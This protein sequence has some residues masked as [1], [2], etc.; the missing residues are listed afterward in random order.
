MDD[1]DAVVWSRFGCVSLT[2]DVEKCHWDRRGWQQS[3]LSQYADQEVV[4]HARAVDP[5][6]ADILSNIGQWPDFIHRLN[7]RVR[8]Q[9]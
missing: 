9:P 7:S 2:M 3:E 4:G 1:K 8:L 6:T 5:V